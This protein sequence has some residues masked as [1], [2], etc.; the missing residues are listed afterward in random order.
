MNGTGRNYRD[1]SKN[2]YILDLDDMQWKQS[3]TESLFDDCKTTSIL[4]DESSSS[5]GLNNANNM[6]L[7][8]G[9]LV[10][11]FKL[12]FVPRDIISIIKKMYSK[13]IIHLLKY[14][15]YRASLTAHC[16]ISFEQVYH[17]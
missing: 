3:R 14:H 10:R 8:I 7:F 13:E 4:I 11:R 16:M 2:I 6:D 1:C 5:D 15:D 12:K 17:S 9:G